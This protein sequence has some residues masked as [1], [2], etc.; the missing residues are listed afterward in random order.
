V[1]A[2]D[3]PPPL[4]DVVNAWIDLAVRGIGIEA[5]WK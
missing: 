4:D 5:A 1:L 2:T 3:P